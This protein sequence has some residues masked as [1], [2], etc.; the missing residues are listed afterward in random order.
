M[1]PSL[2]PSNVYA[3][4][5]TPNDLTVRWTPLPRKEWNGPD[6]HYIVRYRPDD[7][8]GSQF[9]KIKVN[10]P[11]ADHYVIPV[12]DTD[13]PWQPYE[14]QV[15]SANQ[16]GPSATAPE[17][18]KGHTGQGGNLHVFCDISRPQFLTV[19]MVAP[20]SF[21]LVSIES[22][23]S[24][25][26][27]W[28][29]VDHNSMNGP[30]KGYKIYHW[31]GVGDSSA[32]MLFLRRLKRQTNHCCEFL[33]IAIN[34]PQ[35]VLQC[36]LRFLHAKRQSSAHPSRAAPSMIC[37]PTVPTT[38]TL[39]RSTTSMSRRAATRSMLLCLSANQKLYVDF[40]PT[41]A[42]LTNFFLQVEDFNLH[43]VR[44]NE[45]VA[46][47]EE[48]KDT[49]GPLSE[50]KIVHCEVHDDYVDTS[51]CSEA[52]PRQPDPTKAAMQASITGLKVERL[53]STN[54]TILF[55][56]PNQEYEVTVIP[57]TT[58]GQHAGEGIESKMRAKTLPKDVPRSG[59]F[60]GIFFVR[61]NVLS[62]KRQLCTGGECLA[63]TSILINP[64][65]MRL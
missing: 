31:K 14:V 6:F 9:K 16:M 45:L 43:A 3:E 42:H 18:I 49:N 33:S 1:I 27:S 30:H 23:T 52:Q 26:F 56:Q 60:H 19:P 46:T 36:V 57:K 22:G 13:G 38:H 4:G 5:E 62:I 53:L 40:S 17:T 12:D 7:N 24:A 55:L 15:Q 11:Y 47:W 34:S 8:T 28:E 35:F 25:T 63:N 58:G 32:Q 39:S 21:Q 61:E 50:Y 59:S 48:P 51:T 2:N 41:I 65:L 37:T 10:D 20:K 44:P 29:P 64:S 54:K